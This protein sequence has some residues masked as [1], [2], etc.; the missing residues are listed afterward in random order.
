MGDG[1]EDLVLPQERLDGAR[2][3][4]LYDSRFDGISFEEDDE[5]F[6]LPTIQVDVSDV[7]TKEPLLLGK[8]RCAIRNKE[9]GQF[10]RTRWGYA[11]WEDC[12]FAVLEDRGMIWIRGER[13]YYL[14]DSLE[15]DYTMRWVCDASNPSQ[16]RADFFSSGERGEEWKKHYFEVGGH[17]MLI[18]SPY[19]DELGA[20]SAAELG[21]PL[22]AQYVDVV[23]TLVRMKENESLF[24]DDE[25]PYPNVVL[26]DEVSD[27]VRPV[28]TIARPA[29]KLARRFGEMKRTFLRIS[30]SEYGALKDAISR[31]VRKIESWCWN[32]VIA[33]K[34]EIANFTNEGSVLRWNPRL[35]SSV[36]KQYKKHLA[37][38]S[39]CVVE[40]GLGENFV[41][42]SL[43]GCANGIFLVNP[44]LISS[45]RK[46]IPHMLHA[47]GSL[48]VGDFKDVSD[49]FPE[50]YLRYVENQHKYTSSRKD[51]LLRCGIAGGLTSLRYARFFL[52]RFLGWGLMKHKTILS[53]CESSKFRCYGGRAQQSLCIKVFQNGLILHVFSSDP[54][55]RRQSLEGFVIA[56]LAVG[57]RGSWRVGRSGVNG[58]LFK[59]A[60]RRIG[61]AWDM[62]DFHMFKRYGPW[63]G[64]SGI[65][66][67]SYLNYRLRGVSYVNDPR[68][69]EVKDHP[70]GVVVKFLNAYLAC[71][72]FQER[73]DLVLDVWS[74]TVTCGVS[75]PT[76]SVGV[77]F[78]QFMASMLNPDVEKEKR[79]SVV[80]DRKVVPSSSYNCPVDTSEFVD[81]VLAQGTVPEAC[82]EMEVVCAVVHSFNKL[83]VFS[84]K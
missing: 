19:D 80:L 17:V 34:S 69:L 11:D 26:R 65:D 79:G 81:E 54:F 46:D 35:N 59:L 21:M 71:E 56:L 30:K 68:L 63:G 44:L 18:G 12:K 49:Y 41:V 67:S 52:Q 4:D 16:M 25:N 82:Q 62:W 48:A 2:D 42:C 39:L 10:S 31:D 3:E 33:F 37:P 13:G 57:V 14:V 15:G 6:L 23:E 74:S 47:V 66:A 5:A 28:S 9:Y 84:E 73:P 43:A 58:S 53:I 7:I 75:L 83:M 24:V 36:V 29:L 32:D 45:R 64:R 72:F 78:S 77:T 40:M 22:E 1:W 51:F 8:I 20:F 76:C 38:K 50:N 61:A 27:S 70:D 55:M 60:G